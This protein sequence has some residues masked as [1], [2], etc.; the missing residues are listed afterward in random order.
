MLKNGKK[1]TIWQPLLIYINFDF[2]YYFHFS[3]MNKVT[4]R[5]SKKK[6]KKKKNFF[7]F[8]IKKKKKKKGGG[9]GGG[10]SWSNGW[11]EQYNFFVSYFTSI[12]TEPLSPIFEF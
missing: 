5:F 10:G 8:L 12:S 2:V 1:I 3:I 11:L 7:F 6:K 4:N 9:G